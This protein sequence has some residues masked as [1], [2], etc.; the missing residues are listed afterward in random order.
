[1]SPRDRLARKHNAASADSADS[2]AQTGCGL[3]R[4][5]GYPHPV[6]GARAATADA[7]ADDHGPDACQERRIELASSGEGSQGSIFRKIP[8]QLNSPGRYGTRALECVS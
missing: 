8:R 6:K 1:M 4:L 3:P 7:S 2:V 5:R